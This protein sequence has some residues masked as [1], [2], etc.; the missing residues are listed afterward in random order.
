MKMTKEMEDSKYLY[1]YGCRQNTYLF[2]SATYG[3]DSS[4]KS[5]AVRWYT[6][7]ATWA[8]KC[9]A[10]A[11]CPRSPRLL[12]AASLAS[13]EEERVHGR[14]VVVFCSEKS[15]ASGRKKGSERITDCKAK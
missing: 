13:G 5:A 10:S 15:M 11:P 2:L 4:S 6:A 7:F 14:S 1:F 8:V 3:L 9:R 12:A